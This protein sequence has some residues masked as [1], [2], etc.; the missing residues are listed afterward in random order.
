MDA[1]KLLGQHLTDS[2]VADFFSQFGFQ[3]S[4]VDDEGIIFL[5]SHGAGAALSASSDSEIV[6]TVFMYGPGADPEYAAFGGTLPCGLSM[7]LP[8]D[9]VR[10]VMARDPDFTGP[11]YDTWELEAYRLVVGYRGAATSRVT[12]T[13]DR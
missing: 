8:R 3:P 13:I 10:R 5:E 2:V 11:A 6:D 9:D 1:A 12:V 4:R 7:G